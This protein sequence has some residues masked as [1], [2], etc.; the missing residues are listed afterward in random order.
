MTVSITQL[1]KL[2]YA[3]SESK[4]KTWNAEEFDLQVSAICEK[5]DGCKQFKEFLGDNVN[6]A[7]RDV[8]E[9]DSGEKCKQEK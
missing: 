7:A 4:A 9:V 1:S 2:V 6:K 5:T 8:C 3:D